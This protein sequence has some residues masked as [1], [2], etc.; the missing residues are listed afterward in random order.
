MRL[1]SDVP[2]GMFLSGGVDSSAIAALMKRM[3]SR[4]RSRPSPSATAKRSTANW[5]TPARSPQAIGTE[6]HEVVVGMD[7]FFNALPRLIWHEDEPITWPSSV[8]LYFVSQA[9]RRA[10]EGGAH[11]RRQRR[12]V[13]RLRA[14]PLL[15]DEP[16]LAARL[17]HAVPGCCATAIRDQVADHVPAVGAP[18]PQAAAHLRG[19]RRRLE[20]LYLDN[21]YSA[22][23]PP[24]SNAAARIASGAV[25]TR[26]IC[27]IGMPSPALAALAHALRR[28]ENLSG[29]TADEAGPDEHGDLHRKPRAVSRSQFVE[30]S[31]P[32]SRPHEDAQRRRQST[33]SRRP[34]KTCCRTTSSI[35]RRWAFPRRCASG[36]WTRAPNRSTR[37]SRIA[38]DFWLDRRPERSGGLIAVIWRGRR[39]HGSHLAF[40]ESAAVGR[41]VPHWPA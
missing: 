33:S 27:A 9:G 41:F 30:F 10:C 36:C 4:A 37:P 1:M 11:R 8:S 25:P 22:F 24:S 32:R 26:T 40:A 28:P 15:S 7:D 23:S 19:P 20:S 3:T 35:A 39:C 5:A 16:A 29:R 2:L 6:H 17:R 31:T 12:N 13:R 18:P 14:L 21:F 34:W 38:T